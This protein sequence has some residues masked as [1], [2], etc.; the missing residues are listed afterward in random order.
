MPTR[1]ASARTAGR[2]DRVRPEP[3]PIGFAEAPARPRLN[4]L[5][6]ES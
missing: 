6:S 5:R 3:S 2:R 4:A 1:R